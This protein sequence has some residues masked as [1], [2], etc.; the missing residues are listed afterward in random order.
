MIE[1]LHPTV[2]GDVMS[3]VRDGQSHDAADVLIAVEDEDWRR[4]VMPAWT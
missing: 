2:F 3:V 1:Y 4:A